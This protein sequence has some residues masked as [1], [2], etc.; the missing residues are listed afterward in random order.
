MLTIL[1]KISH[2]EKKNREQRYFVAP[3]T[4]IKEIEQEKIDYQLIRDKI[5]VLDKV[6]RIE[7]G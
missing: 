3:R 5:I 6:F 2:C 1:E 4:L 7:R